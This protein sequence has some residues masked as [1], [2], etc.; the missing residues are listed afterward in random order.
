M[1]VPHSSLRQIAPL[2]FE[3]Q[4]WSIRPNVARYSLNNWPIQT[5]NYVCSLILE[6][7]VE[8]EIKAVAR[9]IV[10]CDIP[11]D[12]PLARPHSTPRFPDG[13]KL[14]RTTLL[15]TLIN[16]GFG[17]AANEEHLFEVEQ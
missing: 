1:C 8:A 13:A 14:G 5:L 12:L 15:Q 6:R 2:A 7:Q 17:E 11:L 16:K 4:L 9:N 10:K 3:C